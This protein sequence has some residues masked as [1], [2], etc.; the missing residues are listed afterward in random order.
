MG[1]VDALCKECRKPIKWDG[2][3][4]LCT[5]CKVTYVRPSVAVVAEAERI[6]REAK[7][8]SGGSI[9]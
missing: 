9:S 8:T 4:M 6:L 2:G 7:E 5:G 3:L 1:T